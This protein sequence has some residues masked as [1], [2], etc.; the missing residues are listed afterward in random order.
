MKVAVWILGGLAAAA[1]IAAAALVFT[2]RAEPGGVARFSIG[3]PDGIEF[4]DTLALSPDGKTVVYSA[5]DASGRR[6]YTSAA[7]T[8]SSQ[9][10]FE[11]ATAGAPRFSRLMVRPWDF[12]PA[13]DQMAAARRRCRGG[14]RRTGRERR[15]RSP[16]AAGRHH[17]VS[18]RGPRSAR[19]SRLG[20]CG[21]PAH[22]DRSR[23]RR[24]RAPLRHAG[25]PADRCVVHG[26]LRRSRHAARPCGV[27]RLR[28]SH[29]AGRRQRRPLPA[30]RPYRVPAP[31]IVVGCPIRS[32]ATRCDI[33]TRCRARSRRHCGRLES[34]R[35]RGRERFARIC[36]GKQ[37]YL[38]RAFVRVDSGGREQQVDVPMR[39]W[40]WPQ[41]SPNGKQLGFH[42]MNPVNM[43]VWLY[44]LEKAALIRMT[45]DPRQ[46]RYPVGVLTESRL[47]SG[48]GRM[49]K[50]RTCTCAPRI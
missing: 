19:R 12:R 31:S 8:C 20:R 29:H 34:H 41:V 46:D 17:R 3:L 23:A 9:R 33:S 49:A 2:P 26:S 45:F 50:P 24:A 14:N 6:F 16:V 11:A 32:G 10:P 30:V 37:P 47:L 38:P 39:S 1:L 22:L 44:D 4:R 43:D 13:G 48:P 40:F 35:Q 18:G 42:D 15:R 36:H 25:A 5:S 27:A 7:S 21:S 28:R